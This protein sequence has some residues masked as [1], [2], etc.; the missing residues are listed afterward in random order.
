MLDCFKSSC[1]LDTWLPSQFENHLLSRK[2]P[3]APALDPDTD[4]LCLKKHLWFLKHTLP[5]G[6][7]W[8]GFNVDAGWNQHTQIPHWDTR[9]RIQVLSDY[10]NVFFWHTTFQRKLQSNPLVNMVHENR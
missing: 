5:G 9:A 3:T 6:L 8:L 4:N 2:E 1:L 7:G 10:T